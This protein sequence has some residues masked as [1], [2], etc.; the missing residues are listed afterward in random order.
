MPDYL[1]PE[2]RTTCDEDQLDRVLAWCGKREVLHAD[3]SRGCR[4][5][6]AAIIPSGLMGDA[7]AGPLG[8][9]E[10]PSG[11]VVV[12]LAQT[13]VDFDDSHVPLVEALLEPFSVALENDRR[14][15]E[16]AAMQAAAEADKESLLKR[17]GRKKIDSDC[18][19]GENSGLQ[20]V[21]ER[22]A[23]V[24]RNDAPVLILGETGTGKEL[25]ARMI[26]TQ[27]PRANGPFLR[28][29]CGAIPAELIDS[30]LFGHEKGAFTGAVEARQGWFE[31]AN[32]GTLLLDEAGELPLAVQVRLLRI[33]QDG[34]ME[35]VGGH[36]PMHV[37]VRIVA[38]THRDL[39]AMVTEGRF[40]EDLWYRIAVFPIRLP[41]LRERPEDIPALARHFAERAA[42]RFVLPEAP[43][44]VEDIRLLTSYAWPGNVRELGA[45]IDRAAILGNGKR[46][47]VAGALGAS[48]RPPAAGRSESSPAAPAA[49]SQVLSLDA[50]MKKHIESVLVVA[51]GRVEGR[52]GAAALLKIN[53]HTLRARMRK[54]GI[55][56][57]TYRT[58]IEPCPAT[59]GPI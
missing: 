33:L 9:A 21:M 53:P 48:E 49:S 46:L 29:N 44:T 25:I 20:H 23:L 37:D 16:M 17:L 28:V 31:R 12:L 3:Q 47:D 36:E 57:A 54:L 5:L 58:R 41:P 52:H 2:A 10:N 35:R 50:A 18:I 7:V 30:Q 13:G 1:L 14:L 4:D 55:D 39:A 22:V 27:S 11:G 15:R 59:S 56:W 40:R 26:H 19:V 42:V 43:L 32:G 8:D 38:A 24:A 34:W 6:L 51:H 45:V